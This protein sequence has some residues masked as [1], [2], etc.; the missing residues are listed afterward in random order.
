MT[1]NA[2]GFVDDPSVSFTEDSATLTYGSLADP[3]SGDLRQFDLQI[4]PEPSS[5]VLL[6]SG[7]FALR[8]GFRKR[9]L[10]PGLRKGSH[11]FVAGE[12][13]EAKGDGSLSHRATSSLR[14][15]T[16]RFR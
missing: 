4:V 13:H 6:L 5:S 10:G 9:R 14:D 7:V 12:V 11:R 15:R 2:S 8:G 16:P 1:K 3:F